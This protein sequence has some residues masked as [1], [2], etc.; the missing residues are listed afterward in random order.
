VSYFGNFSDDY[1]YFLSDSQVLLVRKYLRWDVP[2]ASNKATQFTD[3]LNFYWSPSG[4]R[5]RLGSFGY[6]NPLAK[7]D[8]N[9]DGLRDIGV[10]IPP[11]AA[12]GAGRLKV[13]LSPSFSE[14]S[15]I[16]TD[17][18]RIGD[19]PVPADYDTDGRTDFAVYQPGGA[20][21]PRDRPSDSGAT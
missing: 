20:S 13:L 21:P 4:R 11:T 18:G 19:I 6:R 9:G 14:S 7:L 2:L 5:P 10:W 3:G 1:P 16:D 8:F 17:F 15:M 12:G